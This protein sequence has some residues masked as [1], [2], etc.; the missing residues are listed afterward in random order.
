MTVISFQGDKK[1]LSQESNQRQINNRNTVTHNV[2]KVHSHNSH[3]S[4]K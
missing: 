2:D 1:I 3:N 4:Q